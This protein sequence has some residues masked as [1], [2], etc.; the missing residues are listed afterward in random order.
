LTDEELGMLV[1]DFKNYKLTGN[2]PKHFGRDVAYTKGIKL[3]IS[4]K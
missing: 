1:D 2:A 3:V 4:I